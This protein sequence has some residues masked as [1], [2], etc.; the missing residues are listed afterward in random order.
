MYI[1]APNRIQTRCPDVPWV[2]DGDEFYNALAVM[3][4]N[5]QAV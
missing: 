5:L 4:E 1:H 3:C 2:G